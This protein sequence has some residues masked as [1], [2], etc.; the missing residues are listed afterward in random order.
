MRRVLVTGA[1]GFIGRA[2]TARLQESGIQVVGVA[3]HAP[4]GDHHLVPV[5]ITC[6]NDL[7]V[8]FQELRPTHVFHLAAS[9]ERGGGLDALEAAFAVNALGTA[10]VVACAAGTGCERVVVVGTAEE[11]GPIDVPFRED[12]RELPRSIYGITK[13]AGS[14]TALAAGL[15]GGLGVTVVRPTIAYGP[16]QA[17][18]LFLPALLR[19]I[20]DGVPF[21]MTSGHQTRDFLHVD[22]LVE[23][24]VRA[25]TTAAAAG[26]IVNLGS[27]ESITIR[28]VAE[29]VE[30]IVGTHGLLRPGVVPPRAGE[31]M[32]YGVDL[33]RA[34]TL[35]A[36]SATRALE[37]G[38]A[39]TVEAMRP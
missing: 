21:A 12:D 19:S 35:L 34:S 8:V 38:I 20:L 6:R 1:T 18:G 10:N 3:R 16:G 23:G 28:A 25:A 14:R 39:E 29:M 9:L 4:A 27:G 24:L 30:R 13:L 17:T 5:D 36:W 2:L 37:Q 26:L 22:D 32:A 11:Y 33:T 15:L 31:A 7:A